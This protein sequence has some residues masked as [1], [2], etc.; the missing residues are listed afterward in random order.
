V[1]GARRLDARLDGPCALRPPGDPA[2]VRIRHSNQA[3]RPISAGSS[4]AT[5]PS[6]SSLR[7]RTS[8]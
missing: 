6:A 3:L 7:T 4:E 8:K 5:A 2:F 1:V